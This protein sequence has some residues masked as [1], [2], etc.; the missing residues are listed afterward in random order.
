MVFAVPAIPSWELAAPRSAT[1]AKLIL[2]A[3][4]LAALALLA[5]YFRLRRRGL[6]PQDKFA[7]LLACILVAQVPV[8]FG[9]P[10]AFYMAPALM[11]SG[12]ALTALWSLSRP[13][14]A[15]RNHRRLWGGVLAV[16][17]LLHLPQLTVD[18][19]VRFPGGS[20]AVTSLKPGPFALAK[21]SEPASLSR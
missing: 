9:Q 4:I 16:L 18:L 11:L 3:T 21:V 13:L 15:E 19:G 12:P 8:L 10:A 17:A 6:V 5:A 2:S 1:G 14:M 20:R 7:R